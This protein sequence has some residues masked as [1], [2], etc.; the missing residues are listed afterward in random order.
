MLELN[1]IYLQNTSKSF[2]TKFNIV[3]QINILSPNTFKDERVRKK[4]YRYYLFWFKKMFRN[5]MRI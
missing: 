4:L 3:G 2:C 1:N 5:P